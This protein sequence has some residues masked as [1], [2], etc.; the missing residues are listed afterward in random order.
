K[1]QAAK[2]GDLCVVVGKLK[3]KPFEK[4]L[5]EKLDAEW[6]YTYKDN[7]VI[8]DFLQVEQWPNEEDGCTKEDTIHPNEAYRSGSTLGMI[9]FFDEVMPKLIKKLRPESSNDFQIAKIKPFLE[10]I[11]N[12]KYDGD[13][14]YHH[15]RLHWL[16]FWCNRAV[17]LYGDD[18]VIAFS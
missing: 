6:N 13:N 11:N 15:K 1:D 2:P 16:K 5:K 4:V 8:T 9:E 7:F 3:I 12:L 17:E 14:K 18:A 10:E